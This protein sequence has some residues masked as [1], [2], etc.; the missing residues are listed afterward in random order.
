MTS[1]TD[2]SAMR[3]STSRT[4]TRKGLTEEIAWRFGIGARGDVREVRESVRP[5]R[6]EPPVLSGNEPHWPL[7]GAEKLVRR[8]V[9]ERAG[10]LQ[11]AAVE[12]S[13]PRSDEQHPKALKVG[14]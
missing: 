6:Y 1:G 4:R 5:I 12:I 13:H 8:F 7:L 2:A 9:D 3:P 11:P 10:H 14:G